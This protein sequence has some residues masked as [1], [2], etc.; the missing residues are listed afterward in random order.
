MVTVLPCIPAWKDSQ[1][2]VLASHEMISKFS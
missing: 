1:D 2:F